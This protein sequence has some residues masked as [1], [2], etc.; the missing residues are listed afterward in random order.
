MALNISNQYLGS[1]T[2]VLKPT[3]NVEVADPKTFWEIKTEQKSED[4]C[5]SKELFGESLVKKYNSTGFLKG[6]TTYEG[7]IN[8]KVVSLKQDYHKTGLISGYYTYKGLVGD[9]SAD[10]KIES[11]FGSGTNFSGKIGDKEVNLT[12]NNGLFGKYSLV[13]TID[14]KEINIFNGADLDAAQGENDILTT[15]LSLNGSKFSVKNGQFG[16]LELSH[17]ATIEQ[18][19]MMMAQMQQQQMMNQQQMQQHQM[20]HQHQMMMGF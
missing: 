20:M 17:Q 8:D 15:L 19:Q 18:Q 1:T 13:G 12:L 2:S 5:L 11:K 4:L 10:I 7:S 3:S 16:R 6:Y 9:E 14:G